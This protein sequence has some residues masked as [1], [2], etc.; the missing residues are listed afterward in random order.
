M[1]LRLLALLLFISTTLHAQVIEVS[2]GEHNY[3][4]TP[5][6]VTLTKSYSANTSFRVKN[7][8]TGKTAAVQFLD[9]TT[10]AFILPD[11]LTAGTTFQYELREVKVRPAA[12]TV[13][14]KEDKEVVKV[15]IKNKPLFTYHTTLVKPPADSPAYYGRSGFI[16]P[17][18]SPNG[19]IM[20]DDF[21]A[22][23]AHQH[24]LFSAWTN[25]TFKKEFLDF[26]NQHL[27][28]GTVEHISV[29][30]IIQG[31]VF[32]QLQVLLS[33]RSTKYGE[34][35]KEKW[36]I[37]VYP[38]NNYYL[39]DLYSDQLNTSAD[40]LFIN[41][42]HYGGLAFRGSREWNPD[43]KV[44]YKNNWHILTSEGI[45]DTSANGTHA[46]W[47]DA[48][49]VIGGATAG[50][51]VFNHPGNF[52]YPQA[53]RVHPAFPYWCYTPAPD[54]AFFIAPGARYQSR[55]RYF[56]HNGPL[57][58]TQVTQLESEW[59]SPPFVKFIDVK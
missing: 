3:Y 52:R 15:S 35:L 37:T 50:V 55:Y 47:V 57:D 32:G 45:K 12:P 19:K 30:K 14:I 25:T 53:I 42:Y 59:I 11:S 43:D 7:K 38:F 54:G 27:Q 21:P 24:A 28:K 51:T 46:R 31:H 8:Q 4:Q 20:T 58:I 5:V 40:T 48:S 6:F 44:H 29:E 26:W 22:G 33:Y 39:F 49:G 34:V 41:T 16:H 10:L 2:A 23:H 9:N 13:S 18:Y 17:L 56:V 36:T 1:I